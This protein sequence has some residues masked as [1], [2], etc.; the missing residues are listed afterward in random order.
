MLL[1]SML[2]M[3]SINKLYPHSVALTLPLARMIIYFSIGFF[4]S[5][6]QE[7]VMTDMPVS[8]TIMPLPYVLTAKVKEHLIVFE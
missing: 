2:Y 8:I 7:F 5:L 3:V 1:A 6:N 4:K